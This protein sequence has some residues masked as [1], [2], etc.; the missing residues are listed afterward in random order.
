MPRLQVHLVRS[1]LLSAALLPH[2]TLPSQAQIKQTID[3]ELLSELVMAKQEEIRQR[4]IRDLVR[5]NLKGSNIATYNTVL[6]IVEVLLKE[7]NKSAMTRDL[8]RIVAEH[9]VAYAITWRFIR[10]ECPTCQCNSDSTHWFDA[11][12]KAW[13]RLREA[14]S[15]NQ[16]PLQRGAYERTRSCGEPAYEVQLFHYLMDTITLRL[17]AN[18]GSLKDWL[19]PTGLFTRSSQRS[20]QGTAKAE[21]KRLQTRQ[22]NLFPLVNAELESFFTHLEKG[23]FS[24]DEIVSAVS[25]SLPEK[26]KNIDLRQLAGT[27]TWSQSLGAHE[28]TN[29]QVASV[30]ELFRRSVALYRLDE[31]HN[32]LIARFADLIDKY[33]I[34]DPERIDEKS[35]FGFAID[36]EGIILSLEDRIGEGRLSPSKRFF[37]VRPYFTIGLN[38]GGYRGPFSDFGDTT[39]AGVRTVAWAGEKLGLKWRIAD[40]KYARNQPAG[41]FFQYHGRMYKRLVRPK[42][43]YISNVYANVFASGL[44]YTIAD[45]R[46]D[47]TFDHPVV[48]GGAGITWFNG[49]ESNINYV[50]PV[51]SGA[52]FK[53]NI[54][55][56]FWSL[57]LDIPLFEYIKAARAK[58]GK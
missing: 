8:V 15:K 34:L 10:T 4:A 39:V 2:A 45:L 27:K 52:T 47:K 3:E 54:D 36:V 5:P 1:A 46:T 53:E 28:L 23:A 57:A 11:D 19:K 29:E 12:N 38:Y 51:I 22:A 33:L 49:L 9:S 18:E 42:D 26:L 13:E 48:G 55:A 20:W 14:Y 37:N 24:W 43:P 21:H 56:G 31:G 32:H 6:D 44:L 30:F 58:R 17:R 16:G 35:R 50:A 7:K 41:E 40:F 25:N